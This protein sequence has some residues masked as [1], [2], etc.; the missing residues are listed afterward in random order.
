M[1][2]VR[3]TRRGETG[4]RLQDELLVD[5]LD[6]APD[7][8]SVTEVSSAARGKY[9]FLYVNRAFEELYLA[10]KEEVVGSDVV[11]FMSE[12]ALQRDLD[13]TL[14][15][16]G[17]GRAF[18]N[19]RP[20]TRADGNTVWLEVNFRPIVMANQPVRWIF[21][22]RDVTTKKMLQDRATQ[23]SIAVEEGN[24][25][26][27]IGVADEAAGAFR[28]VYVNEA[29][30]RTTGY[31]P[32]EIIGRTF[33]SMMPPGTPS[34]HFAQIRT[35]LFAGEPVRDEIQFQKKNGGIGIFIVNSKPLADPITGK[36]SSI[37]NIY[38]DVTE[39]RLHEAQLLYEAEHDPL[40]GLHNRRYFERMLADS[41]AMQ[42]PS[43]PQH[44]LIF[45][46]LDGFKEVNDR[47]GH[48]AG[49]EVLKIAA[50]AFRHCVVGNDVLV[51]W[52]GDEFAVLLFHCTLESA[53][54]VARCMLEEFER[55]PGRQWVTLS[56]GVAPVSPGEPPSESV[57][58]ADRAAYAAKAQGGGRISSCDISDIGEPPAGP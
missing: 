44:A 45:L 32:E 46:D 5:I 34:E 51:R 15:L 38:R 48:E 54:R 43:G 42:P 56:A 3:P 55:R 41:V 52:G 21:I 2:T 20:Y 29:F 13:K 49:D 6:H 50:R 25:M 18:T 36:Y 40:T 12:R 57:K 7:A 47:L 35:K 53:K 8:V 1:E 14:A 37:V 26:V 11:E 10:K 19:T 33:M 24:D 28:F 23:L 39:E 17:E 22:A 27:S 30:T 16:M 58:R 4:R 31:T 9:T